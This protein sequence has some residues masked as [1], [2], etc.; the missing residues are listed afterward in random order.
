MFFSFSYSPEK[1]RG[2]RSL[3][4][5]RYVWLFPQVDSSRASEADLLPPPIAEI[6]PLTISVSVLYKDLLRTAQ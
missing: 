1:P 4:H 2:Q 6:N 3:L 5:K